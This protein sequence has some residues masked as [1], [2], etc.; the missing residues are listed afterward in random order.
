MLDFVIR[1]SEAFIP[2]NLIF[3]SNLWLIFFLLLR[4]T[5]SLIDTSLFIFFALIIS[6]SDTST[7]RSVFGSRLIN[8][9]VASGST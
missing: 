4:N 5:D 3:Y 2:F 9:L 1:N 6:V 8:V 7:L